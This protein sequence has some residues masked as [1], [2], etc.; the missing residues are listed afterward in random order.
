[1]R[2]VLASH[3]I[4]YPQVKMFIYLQPTSA[5]DGALRVVPG[6]HRFPLHQVWQLAPL[7]SATS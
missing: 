5:D 7:D 6:S 1:M 4:D 3:L 2:C